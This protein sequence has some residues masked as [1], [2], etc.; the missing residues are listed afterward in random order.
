[1]PSPEIAHFYLFARQ[2]SV[3]RNTYLHT[4]VAHAKTPLF[5]SRRQVILLTAPTLGPDK[6]DSS[7][8]P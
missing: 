3:A 4:H 2:K 7:I 6:L 1:V 5:V 8:F